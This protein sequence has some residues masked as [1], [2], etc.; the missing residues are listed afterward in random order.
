[1]HASI[2]EK[3]LASDEPSVRWK[4][5]THVLGEDDDP[6]LRE[7][8][9]RSDRV[10][11]LLA[12]CGSANVYAKWQGAQWALAALADLGYPPGDPALRPLRDRVLDTWLD[13]SFYVEFE[14]TAK[15]GVYRRRGVPVMRGRYRRCASQ[16][17]N[18]LWFL[19][20]LG[21]ADDRCAALAERLLHWQWPDGGWNC[22]KNPAAAT[23]SFAETLLPMRGLAA[24]GETAA[25][26]RAAE[27]LL[28]RRLA[29]RISTG[30]LIRPE[31]AKLHYPLY[32]HYDVLGGLKAVAG[33]GFIGD[34]RSADALDLLESLRVA[35]GWPAHA[36]YYRVSTEIALHN[37]CVDWGGTST[38]RANPWVTADALTV[39]RA[40][41]RLRL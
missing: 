40:A 7:E 34:A 28:A 21:L 26:R 2:V 41:G 39:L 13:P 12:P 25:A 37:D 15:A 29:Y 22:D 18:A 19:H 17:G 1:M 38:R 5:R 24:H 14:A 30:D 23:S 27:V 8:I 20:V 36:R 6:D 32:W 16:Q 4:V 11:R 31:Y 33:A 9:R 10:R 3:L 35:D